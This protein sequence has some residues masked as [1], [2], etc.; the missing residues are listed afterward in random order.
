MA[1]FT[2]PAFSSLVPINKK[3]TTVS[4]SAHPKK[5]F[6]TFKTSKI[7]S[8]DSEPPLSLE[9][10]PESKPNGEIDRV[11]LAFA[12]AKAYKKNKLTSN[13]VLEPPRE[14]YDAKAT[15]ISGDAPVKPALE[16]GKEY[17]TTNSLSYAVENSGVDCGQLNEK[18]EEVSSVVKRA[19]ERAKEYKRNKGFVGNASGRVGET[20][21]T[22]ASGL[23]RGA[24]SPG[25]MRSTKISGKKE[26]L[27]VSSIDFMGLDFSDKKSGRGLP[28]GLV[29]Q[30]DIFPEGDFPEV[31]ILV[32]DMTRFNNDTLSAQAQI[33]VQENG[34]D[35]YKPKVSTWGLFPRPSNISKTVKISYDVNRIY[36]I[37]MELLV[38]GGGRNIQPG[39][40]L[41]TTEERAAKE[42]HTKQLVAS[43]KR[44]IGQNM[45]PKL[46][47]ECEKALTDGDSLMDLGQLKEALPFYE[48]VME[49]LAF[50]SELHGLA[51]LQWSICLDSL[52]RSN[53]A[54]MMYEKLQSHPSPK[55][56]KKAKQF[57]FGFQAMEM[58]KV[59]TSPSSALNTDYQNYFDAFVQNKKNYPSNEAESN[60]GGLNEALPYIIFLISPIFV[61]FLIAAFKFG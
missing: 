36:I 44:K 19:M 51:A 15:E 31:E 58:M 14:P 35:V 37:L 20:E 1:S 46:K 61:V 22:T 29:P 43:Y 8:S 47:S 24:E 56:S 17:G 16:P 18:D 59:N 6:S 57:V 9:N 40:A 2:Q 34:A 54:R 33:P 7:S 53:E 30:P 13:P 21:A 10:S 55:V 3:K 25:N 38:F 32:G 50:Q 4:F 26:G 41:E 12:K 5:N 52:S 23:I 49:K 48:K 45:D 42:A 39:E 28:A 60:G 11:K 27:T